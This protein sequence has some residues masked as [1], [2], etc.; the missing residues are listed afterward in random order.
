MFDFNPDYRVMNRFQ[1]KRAVTKYSGKELKSDYDFKYLRSWVSAS[2]TSNFGEISRYARK[3]TKSD[4]FQS[5]SDE[6]LEKIC[7]EI[8]SEL[9]HFPNH[10][11]KCYRV[12]F[13]QDNNYEERIKKGDFVIEKSFLAASI[14]RGDGISTWGSK[15]RH[16]M[17]GYCLHFIIES[18]TGKPIFLGKTLNSKEKEILFN[19]NTIFKI[20]EVKKVKES[21]FIYMEES[22]LS[23]SNTKVKDIF[24]GNNVDI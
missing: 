11:G 5:K 7:N 12:I 13:S 2:Q 1:R 15:T 21:F 22:G 8:S 4:E 18:L 10:I 20:K 17:Q 14:Y 19:R 9:K 6:Q 24:T 23:S 3:T 16:P